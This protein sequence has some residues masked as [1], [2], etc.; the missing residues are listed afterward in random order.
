ML[1]HSCAMQTTRFYYDTE[2]LERGAA[3]PIDFIS[4][5]IVRA[6]GIEYYAVS[7]QFNVDEV[8]AH[9][10]LSENVWP[11]LPLTDEGELNLDHPVV[12]DRDTIAREVLEFFTSTDLPPQLWAWY[13]AYDH[14][15]LAQLWGAMV[16]MPDQ[17]PRQT[18]DLVT[19]WKRLGRPELPE[20]TGFNHHA[21]YDAQ[22]DRQIDQFLQQ[23][24]LTGPAVTAP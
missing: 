10:F 24:E 3:G 12:K 16:N 18:D 8:R 14:V 2:F 13:A 1:A 21:L 22:H 5:G 19:E 11:L 23:Y 6:D 7:N 4:I 15:V 20:Q 17:L 9:P